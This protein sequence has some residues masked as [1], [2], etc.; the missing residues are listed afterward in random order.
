MTFTPKPDGFEPHLTDSATDTDGF[1]PKDTPDAP[2]LT[3]GTF[4]DGSQPQ[5]EPLTDAEVLDRLRELR[6]KKPEIYGD[7]EDAFVL[8][9]R[10]IAE[11]FE[12]PLGAEV[13]YP[14]SATHVGVARV[15]G[16]ENVVHV[17]PDSSKEGYADVMEGEGYH[18]A[19]VGIEGFT[20]EE[21][22]DVMVAWNS[23]GEPS[24]EIV[25]QTMKQGGIIITNN[26][27]HWATRLSKLPNLQLEGAIL[28]AINVDDA[29]LLVGDEIPAGAAET[30][31]HF[32]KYTDEGQLETGTSQNHDETYESA[33]YPDA[34]F[35]FRV[36]EN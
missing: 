30:E 1:T 33:S 17:D 21:P 32:I 10:E 31:L 29:Q 24:S 20:P 19:E 5:T 18:F 28:P 2:A 13:I 8:A 14:G 15:F 4:H 9:I 11:R 27:T 22:A 35:V 3:A 26:W 34:A 12:I 16:K 23:Y 25:T 36:V 6:D 7:E